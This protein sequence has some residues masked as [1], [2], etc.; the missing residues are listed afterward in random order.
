MKY[1]AQLI[2]MFSFLTIIVGIIY[3]IGGCNFLPIKPLPLPDDVTI[4]QECKAACDN[5]KDLKYPGH[6]G[7]PNGVSCAQVCVDL[8]TGN[9]SFP[10]HGRCIAEAANHTEIDNCYD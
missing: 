6:I 1:L 10:F 3:C 2:W 9:P 7:T 4:E 8:E 5:M